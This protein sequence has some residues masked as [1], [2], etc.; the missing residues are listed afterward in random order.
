MSAGDGEAGTHGGD[1]PKRHGACGDL[2]G[3]R[4]DVREPGGGQLFPCH[5]RSFAV[6]PVLQTHG[7]DGQDRGDGALRDQLMYEVR[8]VDVLQRAGNVVGQGG[9]RTGIDQVAGVHAVLGGGRDRLVVGDDVLVLGITGEVVGED[10]PVVRSHDLQVADDVSIFGGL[11][12]PPRLV[13]RRRL[14]GVLDA[15]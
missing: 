1:G 4:G 2:N 14:L 9:V 3:E 7:G 6:R 11:Q 12:V 5:R 8:V 10:V 13:E 15:G